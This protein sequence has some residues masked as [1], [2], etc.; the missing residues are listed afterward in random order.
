M[1]VWDIATVHQSNRE[2]LSLCAWDGRVIYMM[3]IKSTIFYLH[4]LHEIYQRFIYFLY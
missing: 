4:F 2:M 1:L 3:M